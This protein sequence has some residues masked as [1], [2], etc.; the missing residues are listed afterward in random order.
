MCVLLLVKHSD[1]ECE[2]KRK[3][4]QTDTHKIEQ[5]RT[6]ITRIPSFR[7]CFQ[8]NHACASEL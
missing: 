3:V 5:L 2:T 7:M 6:P 1:G 8:E 4:A